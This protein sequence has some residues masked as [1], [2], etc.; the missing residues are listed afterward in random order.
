M[1]FISDLKPDEY[2]VI[3]RLNFININ[4]KRLTILKVNP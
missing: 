2:S 1:I 4:Q 3:L